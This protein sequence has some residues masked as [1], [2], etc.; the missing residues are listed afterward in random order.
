MV[1]L[2]GDAIYENECLI[3]DFRYYRLYTNLNGQGG[4]TTLLLQFTFKTIGQFGF[5]AL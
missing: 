3:V 5:H 4:S 2:G 1:A